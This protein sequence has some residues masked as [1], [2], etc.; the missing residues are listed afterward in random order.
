M[1]IDLSMLPATLLD[2]QVMR[3]SEPHAH[4][5]AHAHAPLH[6][7]MHIAKRATWP[8]NRVPRTPQRSPTA[9]PHSSLARPPEDT[10]QVVPRDLLLPVQAAQEAVEPLGAQ[11]TVH[12]GAVEVKAFGGF[13]L[14][15]FAPRAGKKGGCTP[16][17]AFSRR[18]QGRTLEACFLECLAEAQCAHVFVEHVEVGWMAAPPPLSCTLL[19]Q[20]DEP[21]AACTE[22][23]GPPSSYR[24]LGRPEKA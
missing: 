12:L 19:G 21:D 14:A 13:S 22:G 23:T 18:A 2:R 4:A 15:A 6:M 20:L 8:R 17:D 5:R 1:T 3:L 24:T 9:D 16:A 7:H 10:W 11:W